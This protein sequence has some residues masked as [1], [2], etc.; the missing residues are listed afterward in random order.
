MYMKCMLYI[1]SFSL[2]VTVYSMDTG[3]V[4]AKSMVRTML[5]SFKDGS[6]I[7]K[8]SI[9]GAI[10]TKK[11]SSLTINGKYQIKVGE[12]IAISL[13]EA[14]NSLSV[15]PN[16]N[17][18]SESTDHSIL[19][20]INTDTIDSMLRRRSVERTP[21]ATTIIGSP[22]RS[23]V[24][25]H[26][27]SQ[28]MISSLNI[29]INEEINHIAIKN[30]ATKQLSDDL[31]SITSSEVN[32]IDNIEELIFLC[33]NIMPQKSDTLYFNNIA[34]VPG[35]SEWIRTVGG[36]IEVQGTDKKKEYVK[37]PAQY[38]HTEIDPNETIKTFCHKHY[39]ALLNHPESSLHQVGDLPFDKIMAYLAQAHNRLLFSKKEGKLIVK[40]NDTIIETPHIETLTESLSPD[41]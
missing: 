32:K 28:P 40:Y 33:C 12:Q 5:I 14:D 7:N 36:F 23:S 21:T 30:L 18:D 9:T 35:Q 3:S 8:D 2:S 17:E 11:L 41:V 27:R 16:I 1:V 37:L 13:N 39:W 26:T 15:L 10:N 34:V 24:R 22:P 4:Q 19:E 31:W 20:P 38:Q 29:P 6:I 25:L